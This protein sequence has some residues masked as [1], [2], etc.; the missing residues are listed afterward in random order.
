MATQGSGNGTRALLATQ[1][2]SKK[3]LA[4]PKR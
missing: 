2:D 4:S 1:L 3:Y